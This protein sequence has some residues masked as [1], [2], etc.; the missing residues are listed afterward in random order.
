ET[1][2]EE[3]IPG[4]DI[5]KPNAYC[6][7]ERMVCLREENVLHPLNGLPY[8]T[9]AQIRGMIQVRDA[10]RA[11]LRSQ[12]DGSAEAEVADARFQLNLAYDRFIAR[13]GPLNLRAN[14]RAFD[15]DPD[16]PLLL[17]LEHF[18][19]ETKRAT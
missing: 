13:F 3:T 8:E 4:P 6:L 2:I 7:H 15:G 16:S 10:V 12:V 18:N 17:S 11:C 5:I 1:T 19:D 9:R 14:Q